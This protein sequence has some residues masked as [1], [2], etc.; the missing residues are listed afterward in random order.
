MLALPWLWSHNTFYSYYESK[1]F[2]SLSK[3]IVFILNESD[4]SKTDRDADNINRHFHLKQPHAC[5]VLDGRPLSATNHAFSN[6]GLF[7]Q[8][9]ESNSWTHH[10][11]TIELDIQAL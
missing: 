5:G 8:F 1:K 11:H 3:D 2:L 10:R 4:V 7:S 9:P 6:I